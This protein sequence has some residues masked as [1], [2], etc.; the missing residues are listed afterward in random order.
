MIGLHVQIKE[1]LKRYK[2]NIYLERMKCNYI[3]VFKSIS[4]KNFKIQGVVDVNEFKEY[5]Q[6][7][8][9]KQ[10][11]ETKFLLII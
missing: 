1:T 6:C 7:Y 8:R 10:W 9:Q 5:N 11:A 3:F 2:K 4:L